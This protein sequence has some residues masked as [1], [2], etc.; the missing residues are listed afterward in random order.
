MPGVYYAFKKYGFLTSL[1]AGLTGFV[2]AE[3]VHRDPTHRLR[4][5]T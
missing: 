3:V 1:S 4:S 2:F 5:V